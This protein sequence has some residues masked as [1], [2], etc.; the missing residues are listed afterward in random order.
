MVCASPS[1]NASVF[2]LNS[3]GLVSQARSF[4]FVCSC[5]FATRTRED[6]IRPSSSAWGGRRFVP[7]VFSGPCLGSRA[8][9]NGLVTDDWTHVIVLSLFSSTLFLFHHVFEMCD[10]GFLHPLFHRRVRT[11][12][13]PPPGHSYPLLPTSPGSL[14]FPPGD[15]SE[16]SLDP[17]AWDVWV[18]IDRVVL[19]FEPTFDPTIGGFVP[20]KTF[21]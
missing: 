12:G 2:H 20:N 14:L 17:R 18:P 13:S 3:H 8:V 1:T 9:R 4:R 6:F 21:L 7:A 16:G 11:P 5:T 19:G 10:G 15:P